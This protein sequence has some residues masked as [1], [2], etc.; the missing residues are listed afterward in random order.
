MIRRSI[1]R[2]NKM[3]MVGNQ[4]S[5]SISHE[6]FVEDYYKDLVILRVD[7]LG[8]IRLHTW[9]AVKS[10]NYVWE[11]IG[12]V[13][14]GISIWASFQYNWWWFLIGFILKN[15]CSGIARI[16]RTNAVTDACL[17]NKYLYD[18]AVKNEYIYVFTQNE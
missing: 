6:R 2:N 4:N 14:L 8:A 11:F 10:C 5:I 18:F 3:V 16:I 9:G 15:N 7:N 12:F 1:I 13:L 17:K